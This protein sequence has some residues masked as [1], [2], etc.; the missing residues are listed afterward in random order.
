ME[1]PNGRRAEY[2]TGGM[3]GP[4]DHD[5][6]GAVAC[7]GLGAGTGQYCLGGRAG[8]VSS[9]MIR[10]GSGPGK[11][12]PPAPPGPGAG[13]GTV[14]AGTVLTGTGAACRPAR[15]WPFPTVSARTGVLVLA[16]ETGRAEAGRRRATTR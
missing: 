8:A 7:P 16:S 2:V 3:P 12:A 14:R 15:N 4:A 6:R 13:A 1:E 5:D 9:G 10:A 11:A